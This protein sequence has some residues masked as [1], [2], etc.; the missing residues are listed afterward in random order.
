MGE[1]RLWEPGVA[2]SSPVAPRARS[3]A[4]QSKGFLIPRSGVR[5]PPGPLLIHG[6]GFSS[7]VFGCLVGIK[8]DL[9]GHGRSVNLVYRGLK[10]LVEHLARIIPDGT[11]ALGWSLGGSLC[12]LLA[13]YFPH[14]VR[15]LFLIGSTDSFSSC[16][17][18]KNIRGFLLRLRK[19]GQA[20]VEDFRKR[21]YGEFHEPINMQTATAL[22][23]DYLS[24][25]LSKELR[26]INHPVYILHGYQDPVVPMRCGK[27]LHRMIKGSKFIP[28]AGG[29]LP[30]GY[31]RV[32]LEVLKSQ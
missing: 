10:G 1:H 32:V 22:L 21:A 23:E 16:W 11:D 25:D 19:E 17:D 7:S 14:K 8:V 28:L 26:L 20:F 6:W 15:R 13:L 3:S 5:V 2:G 29:H 31:E 30:R 9:P 18:K 4:G 27:R 24:L 12:M